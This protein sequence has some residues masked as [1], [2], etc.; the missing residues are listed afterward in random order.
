MEV[1]IQKAILINQKT[2]LNVRFKDFWC[3]KIK[4]TQV[5]ITNSKF[6]SHATRIFNLKWLIIVFAKPNLSQKYILY[7]RKLKYT[8]K[9]WFCNQ[10]PV[11]NVCYK[12]LWYTK[13]NL[14][15]KYLL[16]SIRISCRSKN[17]RR[18]RKVKCW[19][20]KIKEL[21]RILNSPLS[22]Q[23]VSVC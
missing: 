11:L 20:F 14:S 9:R 7:A 5:G 13:I 1:L 17:D 12:D 23:V 15:K 8:F 2:V 22:A 6:P 18:R 3:A 19:N 4:L 16:K 21:I 10:K